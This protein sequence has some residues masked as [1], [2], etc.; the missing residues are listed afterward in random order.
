MHEFSWWSLGRNAVG[1]A[2]DMKGCGGRLA[3]SGSRGPVKVPATSG[4]DWRNCNRSGSW[5]LRYLP[6]GHYS[7]A[8]LSF[9]AN[10][11]GASRLLGTRSMNSGG[12]V[13]WSVLIVGSSMTNLE[14]GCM[15]QYSCS[16]GSPVLE[17]EFHLSFLG[18]APCGSLLW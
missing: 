5:P 15:S 10:D 12:R 4:G 1:Q 7:N 17:L 6:S 11:N 14:R 18:I 9:L 16:C 13:C 8:V 2:N 3:G